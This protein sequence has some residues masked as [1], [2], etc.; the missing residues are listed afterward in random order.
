MNIGDIIEEMEERLDERLEVQDSTKIPSPEDLPLHQNTGSKLETA[1]F[2]IDLRGYSDL[3]ESRRFDTVGR[4]ISAFHYTIARFIKFHSGHIISF[5]GDGLL[6]LF[7]PESNPIENAVR[8]A[9]KYKY[10]FKN[11]FLDKIKERWKIELDYGIGVAY[12]QIIAIRTGMRG[13]NDITWVGRC[14]KDAVKIGDYI[15]NSYKNVGITHSVYNKLPEGLERVEDGTECWK[16]LSTES[17]EF[18]Y[19]KCW[20]EV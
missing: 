1:A 12:G 7:D 11:Y 6:A 10:F 3:L 2:Y 17:L 5:M 8:C 9:L 4:I 15:D 20:I 14:I 18:Y 19:T 13:E 16:L